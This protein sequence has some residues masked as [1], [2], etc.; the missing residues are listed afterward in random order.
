MA[1]EI[2]SDDVTA[3]ESFLASLLEQNIE[4]G[5]FTEGTALRDLAVKGLAFIHS[6]M[7]KENATVQTLQSLL[8]I[9]NLATTSDPQQDRTVSTAVDSLLSNWFLT[10]KVGRFSRGTLQVRVSRQQDYVIPNDQRFVYSR[11]VSFF[12][13]TSTTDDLVVPASDLQPFI[14]TEGNTQYYIMTLRL[15]AAR[16]G[17]AFN[18]SPAEWQSPG[19]FSP[20]IQGASNVEKFSGGAAKETTSDL[21]IR[22]NS[23]IAERSLINERS[24]AATLQERFGEL[25]R[26]QVIGMGDPEMYRDLIT[27]YAAELTMHAGGHYDV[28]VELPITQATFEGVL[29][30]SFTRPDGIVNIFRDGTITDWTAT[31]VQV[32]DIIRIASGLP[33]APKDFTI[34][35][36][37]PSELRVSEERPFSEVLDGTGS[38]ADY[39]IYRPLFGA[40]YQV[41]PA[42]GVNTTG[43]T[44]NTVINSGRIL[45]PGNPVYDTIDVAVINP[46]PG[47]VYANGADGF[48][49]FPSRQNDTPFL[50]IDPVDLNYQ[51]VSANIGTTQSSVQFVELLLPDTYDGKTVRVTYDTIAGYSAIDEYLKDRFER[52]L[53]SN[54]LAKGFHPVYLSFA[55]NFSMKPTATS[56]VD[57]VALRQSLVDFI[58]EFSPNDVIDTSDIVAHIREYSSDIGTVYPLII[59]YTLYSPDGNVVQFA[60]EDIVSVSTDK[61]DEDDADFFQEPS[62]LGISDR[63]IRYLTTFDRVSVEQI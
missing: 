23:A 8:N 47:D 58:N 2:S 12:L 10:R 30:G 7:K 9:N 62:E 6:Y 5:R 14:D 48:V 25:N 33:E 31:S 20:Y 13:D 46:D 37:L 35:E 4:D 41:L 59:N 61:V 22:A 1:I 15:V 38:F 60:T 54:P 52:I 55:A 45:L 28:Y 18:V 51:V 32:G 34:R 11:N 56:V 16:T 49:H 17:D 21:I 50:P 36:V 19:T 24:I 26:L 63:V 53:A 39:F 42:V 57:T 3:A 43:V 27:E 44:A 40:D 29:G